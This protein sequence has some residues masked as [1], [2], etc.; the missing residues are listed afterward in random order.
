MVADF[1]RSLLFSSSI[2]YRFS[3]FL[4][5]G[6]LIVN[7]IFPFMQHS[8]D[9]H[10][11]TVKHDNPDIHCLYCVSFSLEDL[12][13]S[14]STSSPPPP[15]VCLPLRLPLPTWPPPLPDYPLFMPPTDT[16][17]TCYCSSLVT[18]TP[19]RTRFMATFSPPLSVLPTNRVSYMWNFT[20][21]I[22]MASTSKIFTMTTEFIARMSFHCLWLQDQTNHQIISDSSDLLIALSCH[23]HLVSVQWHNHWVPNTSISGV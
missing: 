11:E 19:F 14:S 7:W 8:E 4:G 2:L 5:I 6:S 23:H 10:Q 16:S 17:A 20:S 12:S 15:S 13:P 18:T 9:S 3:N 1:L 21:S 22:T